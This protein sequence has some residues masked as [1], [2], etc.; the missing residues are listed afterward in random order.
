MDEFDRL[1]QVI[2]SGNGFFGLSEDWGSFKNGMQA[3]AN[4]RT[5][6]QADVDA[7]KAMVP[8]NVPGVPPASAPP[9]SAT[10]TEGDSGPL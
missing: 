9:A 8:Q 3:L 10:P 4:W 5:Q 6:I 2:Q 7:L 1:I